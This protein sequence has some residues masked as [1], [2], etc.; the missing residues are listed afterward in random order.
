[1]SKCQHSLLSIIL[2]YRNDNFIRLNL[3]HPGTWNQMRVA[4]ALGECE[5][6][7]YWV[8]IVLTGGDLPC[9]LP[10]NHRWGRCALQRWTKSG[11]FVFFC[12]QTGFV[13]FKIAVNIPLNGTASVQ[14]IEFPL[15]EATTQ[16]LWVQMWQATYTT[17]MVARSSQVSGTSA[18]NL[19]CSP[20]CPENVART[21]DS[22]LSIPSQ[23]W[24][25]GLNARVDQ[26]L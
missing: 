22:S 4:W 23:A 11:P 3:L 24:R 8:C 19:S 10:G 13:I 7:H 17:I 5:S 26:L 6:I 18:I 20:K 16:G 9:C 2:T 21:E 25:T 14:Q 12:L 15:C 1:M